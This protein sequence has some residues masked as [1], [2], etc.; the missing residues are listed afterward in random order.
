MRNLDSLSCL[1]CLV[2]VLVALLGLP[3][4]ASGTP[5]CGALTGDV[6]WTLEGSPYEAT[7]DLEVPKG[8]VLTIDPGVEVLLDAGVE[9][10]VRGEIHALGEE[11]SPVVL[12]ASGSSRWEG[13]TIDHD[14]DG[15]ARPSSLRHVRLSRGSTLLEVHT[16]GDSEILVEH[17]TFD[18]WNGNALEWDRSD[19]L[20]VSHCDFGLETP[21]EE[22]ANETIHGVRAATIIEYCTFS[23]RRGYNDVMDI[24][25]SSWPGPVPTVRYNL[26]LGGE[27]DAID[28]D[29]ADGWIIGNILMDFWPLPGASSGGNGGGITGDQGSRPV[30]AH[31]I[32]YHCYHGIGY[33]NGSAPLLVNNLVMN[34]H[35]G[36]TFYKDSCSKSPPH[37]ILF[38]NILWNNRNEDTAEL[39]NLVLNGAWWPAYCQDLAPQATA[40]VS[41]CLI[42]GGWEGEGNIDLD[43]RIVDPEGGDFSLAADSPALDAAFGGPFEYTGVAPALLEAVLGVDRTGALPVDI[44]CLPDEGAGDP[45]YRDLGPLELELPGPCTGESFF[46]R[47]DSNDDGDIDVSDAVHLL[48]HLFTGLAADDCQD[49]RDMNDD[50]ELELTDAVYLLNHLFL[51]QPGPPAPYPAPGFDPTPDGLSCSR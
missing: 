29:N 37:G 24:S 6:H 44:P 34:C 43:P 3:T 50:G 25:D 16:T 45:T 42:Q 14:G 41:Y 31:N 30:I 35:V 20:H 10:L 5:V 2:A 15:D 51:A 46:V 40:D 17:C 36:V 12:T 1:P 22:S 8:S 19:G 49:A 48:L 39:Q 21:L 32:V 13:V 26:F 38:N 33:K 23:P 18:R 47:G 7:C 28:Y 11:A 27:D 9:L 4:V